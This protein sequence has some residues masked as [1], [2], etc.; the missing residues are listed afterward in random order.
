MEM[1]S[2]H[3]RGKSQLAVSPNLSLSHLPAAGAEMHRV[4]SLAAKAWPPCQ[5]LQ[6]WDG[7]LVLAVTRH[8]TPAEKHPSIWQR[9]QVGA[10]LLNLGNTCYMNAALQCLTY[11]PPLANV[12]L[13]WEQSPSCGPQ[14]LC[15]LCA[16]QD[17]ISRALHHPGHV[18]QPSA[19]LVGDFHRHQ[20]EDA[21]EFLMSTLDAM[22]RACLRGHGPFHSCSKD[23]TLIRQIFGGYWRSRVQC[24][25]CQRVSDTFDPYLDITLD[26]QAAESVS[27][28]LEQLVTTEEL[29]GDN[30]YHCGICHR[31]VP[32]SKKLT[33]HTCPEVLILVLKRFSDMTGDKNAKHVNYPESLDLSRCISGQATGAAVYRLYAV[34][35][36]VGLTCHTGHYLSY[37]KTGNGKWYKMDDAKLV[38]CD[39]TSALNQQAYVLFYIQQWDLV[40][41][42]GTVPSEGG[43]RDPE[44]KDRDLGTSL[45]MPEGDA[46]MEIPVWQE[47]HLEDT[48][49]EP[50][51]LDEWKM[52]QAQER[53]KADFKLRVIETALPSNA[54]VIHKSKPLSRVGK[55]HHQ[56]EVHQL[57]DPARDIPAQVAINFGSVLCPGRGT[58][59]SKSKKKG[60]G[61]RQLHPFQKD[62]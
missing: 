50:M 40:R 57:K 38:A 18:L 31:K 60:K 46:T 3:C 24:L 21:H 47:E 10:G 36:H 12:M 34:L 13:S 41:D 29:D 5:Y 54:V 55:E 52:L 14:G 45:D 17:H 39:M 49:T 37:V 48:A 19:A 15:M 6:D 27:Q 61:P 59:G 7:D 16:M 26:I 9:C 25:R 62:S 28:A 1:S 56:Q 22:H 23:T 2:L 35:V 30:S 8:L 58:R 33:L 43:A 20:Q 51:T 53:P 42:H 32:A 44:I 4:P 11:T